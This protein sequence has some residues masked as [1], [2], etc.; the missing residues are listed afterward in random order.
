[1]FRG[2]GRAQFCSDAQHSVRRV[3]SGWKVNPHASVKGLNAIDVD[4]HNEAVVT[5]FEN[6][7]SVTLIQSPISAPGESNGIGV[8]TLNGEN[9]RVIRNS[10]SNF[11]DAMNTLNNEMVYVL[12]SPSAEEGDRNG[13]ERPG[14]D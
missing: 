12:P 8:M 1:M 10:S 11:N 5:T 2:T 14:R 9:V 13:I 4:D 6:L 3:Q 7:K